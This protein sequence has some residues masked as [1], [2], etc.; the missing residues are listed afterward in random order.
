MRSEDRGATVSNIA[1]ANKVALKAR[2][3]ILSVP[4]HPRRWASF[5]PNKVATYRRRWGSDFCLVVVGDPAVRGDFYSIPWN[6]VSDLFTENNFYPSFSKK[7]GKIRPLWKIHLAGEHVFQLE[8]APDNDRERL[9][10]SAV[11]WYAN[12]NLLLGTSTKSSQEV[13]P[14][15]WEL[16]EEL[17]QAVRSAELD[18]AELRRARLRDAAPI[19]QKLKVTAVSY[20]R[21][22]D[23]IV[24][25][26]RR[27]NGICDHCKKPAPFIRSK[28]GTPYLEVHHWKPLADGG[29]DTLEN[30]G[31]VCPNCHRELHYGVEA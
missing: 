20:R 11:E 7:D 22:P 24:E 28:D 16:D 3:Y 19:P 27:A 30:A 6:A 29:E 17:A 14:T 23:V 15:Q 2:H 8:L 10:F 12:E 1:E 13:Y 18:S 25:V 26:L 5:S 9:R 31:A 21:N 4:G